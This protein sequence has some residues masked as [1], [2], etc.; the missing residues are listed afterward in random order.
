MNRRTFLDLAALTTLGTTVPGRAWGTDAALPLEKSLPSKG[1]ASKGIDLDRLRGAPGWVLGDEGK[2]LTSVRLTREWQGGSCRSRITNLGKADVRVREVVLFSLA[3]ELPGATAVYGES[4]QMLSQTAG[5]LASP[6]H[7]GYD[8]R[9]HY[10]VPQPAG[11]A[12]AVTGLLMLTPPS[13]PTT[14]MAFASCRRFA[15]RFYLR[16]GAVEGVLDGEDLVLAP[17][18]TWDLEELFLARGPDQ[19]PLLVSLAARINRQHPP[20]KFAKPPTGWCSWYCF[21]PKVTADDVAQNL[22]VIAKD[23][24]ALRYVQIDDGYQPAM[25]DWL[26]TGKAFGGDVK[27]VLSAIRKRGFEPAIWVAPFIAEA[28]SHIF[29]QHPAWFV[30]GDD[31][32]PL[33][34]DRVTFAGWRRGPWYMLDGTH[35]EVQAHFQRLFTTMQKE[36]GCTY[37]KLDANFWGAIHGGHFHDPK[38]T[39]IEAYRRGMA[40]ILRGTGHSFILGCNHPIW[41]SFGL[42]HGSRSSGDVK[43]TWDRF[44]KIARQN[45]SRNWQNGSLWWNDSDAVCLTG[46]LSDDEF[47]FHATAVYAS[48]GLVLSGDDLTKIPPARLAMLKKLLPPTARAAAFDKS[49]LRVGRVT[50][51][52]ARMLCL[53][54]F[55]DQPKEI[56]VRLETACDI[57]DFWSG[58]ALGRHE[59]ILALG[60][61]PPHSARL[62]ACRA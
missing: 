6:E 13:E 5:T 16:P 15:G 34:A 50:V 4:L 28:G 62:L 44:K 20:L 7:L 47:Q 38:A 41:A 37:F 21:G 31:S 57:T 19:A 25:G 35:P 11:V 26:E 49:D 58:A 24:P 12:H 10:K 40:A 14:L 59:G 27:G 2:K 33:P 18:Q 22:D 61:M 23:V 48:G 36:W 3:H 46:S 32:K 60:P 55:D 42:I 53:F 9:Q 52:D 54:N 43:R 51:G 8:E 39:R 45:L 56:S 1:S 29:Q 30:K 17:G